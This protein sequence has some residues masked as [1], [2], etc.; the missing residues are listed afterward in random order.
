MYIR[1]IRNNESVQSYKLDVPTGFR[2]SR[3]IRD[4]IANAQASLTM[5]KPLTAWITTN[6]T[7]L[8]EMGITDHLTT[9]RTRHGIAD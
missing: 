8:Q 7:I 1:T 3:G 9:V 4:Q 2:N 5:L 6:W